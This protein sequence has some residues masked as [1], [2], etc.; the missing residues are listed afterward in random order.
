M[1][2]NRGKW[3]ARSVNKQTKIYVGRSLTLAHHFF[4]Y[5]LTLYSFT[6]SLYTHMN[7]IQSNLP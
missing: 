3:L 2:V 7:Y 5:S 4:L 6:H 1:I